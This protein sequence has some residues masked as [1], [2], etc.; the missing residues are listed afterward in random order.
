[1]KMI[2]VIDKTFHYY[3]L[4]YHQH[5]TLQIQD[6]DCMSNAEDPD[7]CGKQRDTCNNVGFPTER[8]SP[9]NANHS[10][11]SPSHEVSFLC[12]ND[13]CIMGHRYSLE[14]LESSSFFQCFVLD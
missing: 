14:T 10:T 7:V 8:L 3:F 5:C 2:I 1:M 11:A 4:H 13:F 6:Y 12:Y 9:E